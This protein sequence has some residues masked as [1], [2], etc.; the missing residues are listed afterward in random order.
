M[1]QFMI[2]S[3]EIKAFLGK[4]DRQK[5]GYQILSGNKIR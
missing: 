5:E 2:F 3:R 4:N 1:K